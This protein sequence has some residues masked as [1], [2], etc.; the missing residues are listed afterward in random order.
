[1]PGMFTTALVVKV[2][3]QIIYLYYSGRAHTGDNLKALL[4][5]RETG[6]E[7][8]LVMSDT[9]SRNVADEDQLIRCHC[10]A[11]GRRKFSDLEDVFPQECEVVINA[12][13][14]VFD[15]DERARAEQMSLQGGRE[16]TAQKYCWLMTT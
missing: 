9:L 1:M 7:K 5:Q 14:Q 3:E 8:P 16:C 2:G 6:R 4:V 11:H 15:R 10:L 12:L 13:T